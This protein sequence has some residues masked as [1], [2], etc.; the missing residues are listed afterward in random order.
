MKTARST[1]VIV[2]LTAMLGCASRTTVHLI[3]GR[4]LKAD[5]VHIDSDR[6]QFRSGGWD[7]NLPACMVADALVKKPTPMITVTVHSG[8]IQTPDGRLESFTELTKYLD[9]NASKESP[10]IVQLDQPSAWPK[11]RRTE[12]GL[13]YG[14]VHR[15]PFVGI[16]GPWSQE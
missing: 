1:L 12:F 5:V 15:R 8:A 11:A 14:E 7:Y 9:E 2:A 4:S 10:I 16:Q 3:D 13:A 6:A